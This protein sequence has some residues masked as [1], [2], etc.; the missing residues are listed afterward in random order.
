ML[1]F[2]MVKNRDKSLLSSILDIRKI[3]AVDK[4]IE[5][6]HGLPNECY[7]SNEYLKFE[8]DKIFADKWTVIGVGSSIPNIGD[9]KPYSLLGIPLIMLRDKED[10]I[11]VFHNVC[12]H[13]GFKLLDEPCSLKNVLRCPYHSWSYDF[14]GKLVATP[15]IGGLNI[16]ETKKFDKSTSNL[17]EVRT[18]VWMDIIFVN[19]NNNE[20]EFDEYIQPLEN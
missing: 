8:R 19:I 1:G 15:H 6:A 11:R 3:K 2:F 10:K 20:L 17:K 9:A 5:E 12:S 4:P 18:K 16:H 14:D 7:T 13:R